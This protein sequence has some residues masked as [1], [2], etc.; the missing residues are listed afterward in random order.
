MLQRRR[1]TVDDYYRMAEAGILAPD[2]RVELLD[3]EVVPM[4]PIGNRHAACVD[5]LARLVFERLGSRVHLR[6]Q[7]PVRLDEHSEPEPDVALLR[8]R[9]DGYAGGHPT[10]DDV[11]LVVEVADASLHRDRD[12]KLPLY[13]RAG[14]PEVWVVDLS[15]HT[16]EV[17]AE[18]SLDG[19]GSARRARTGSLVPVEVP[20]L[21]LDVDEIVVRGAD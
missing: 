17:Y 1:F 16:V 9:D 8:P 13:A 6:I 3:G 15:S 21:K 18:P 2:E 19:Y 4:T 7:N 20:H 12:L 14:V 11:L 10:P 5:R